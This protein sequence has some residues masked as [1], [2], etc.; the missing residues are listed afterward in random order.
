MKRSILLSIVALLT[1]ADAWTQPK[2]WVNA[3]DGAPAWHNALAFALNGKIY[4]CLGTDQ[5]GN[6]LTQLRQ[7]DPANGVWS[8]KAAFP[9]GAR[10]GAVCFTVNN[11]AYVAT[12]VAGADTLNDLWEY[13]PTLDAWNARADLPGSART[14]AFAFSIDPLG[15]VATGI[16]EPLPDDGS[17]Y[18]SYPMLGDLWVYDPVTDM[19]SPRADLFSSY[20]VYAEPDPEW[21]GFALGGMGYMVRGQQVRAYDPV[22]N[23]WA[24]MA[25]L[26]VFTLGLNGPLTG[27]AL[28]GHGYLIN[29]GRP[30]DLIHQT[31]P[32]RMVR[33]DPPADAWRVEAFFPGLT[34]DHVA[35]AVSGPVAYLMGGSHLYPWFYLDDGT[36]TDDYRLDLPQLWTY[37]VRDC[38]GTVDGPMVPGD[39]CDDGNPGTFN[40]AYDLT[41]TCSGSTQPAQPFHPDQIDDTFT[42]GTGF[43]GEVLALCLQPDGKVIAAGNFTQYNGTACNGIARLHPDGSIDAD[44]N[45]AVGGRA[46]ALQPNGRILVGGSGITRLMPDGSPD[47]SFDTYLS[48]IGLQPIHALAVRPDGSILAGGFYVTTDEWGNENSI[49]LMQ[50]MPDGSRDPAFVPD[51]VWSTA[52]V[53]ALVLRPDGRLLVGMDNNDGT[54]GN[55]AFNLAELLPNGDRSEPF[56]NTVGF[57]FYDPVRAIAV[58]PDDFLAIGGDF[59]IWDDDHHVNDGVPRAHMALLEPQGALHYAFDPGPSTDGPVRTLVAGPEGRIIAGGD[60]S[61]YRNEAHSGIVQ[62]NAY[63]YADPEFDPGT[64]F[65]AAVNVLLALPNGD[66][67]VGGAFTSYDGVACGHITRLRT[68]GPLCLPTQLTTTADPVISCGAV[69]L[70]F[71][72]TSTIAATEVPGANRYQFR[73]TNTPGQPAYTRHIAF[74]SRSF[75]LQKWYTLPL[76]AGRTYNVVVRASFDNGA[77]WCDWGPSCTVKISWTPLAPFAEPRGM[78][79]AY[80]EEPTEL[81]L[82]PNPTNGDQVRIELGGID[83]ELAVAS[84]DI[85]ALFGKRVWST[86]LPLQDGVLNTSLT[87]PGDL[88][89]GLYVATIVA[90]EQLFTERL[91]IAR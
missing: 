4:N 74:P 83:P 45:G 37:D 21:T 38:Q 27:F 86:P 51:L 63:G 65:D 30:M 66:L 58:R 6:V 68:S 11:K 32:N 26:D 79:T 88:A 60:F 14:H 80:T 72:G 77:T 33:Y 9:G 25:D 44:F 2:T 48:G 84:L 43:D 54:G 12:G 29:M 90:G 28:G 16:G 69:N 73:F 19:W 85:T 81:L 71:N 7:Y 46:L 61:Y 22:L 49:G 39:P 55:F 78:E 76:K 52:K 18:M 35:L 50:L 89:G 31:H 62:V 56:M 13:D 70:K 91:M 23:T 5:S 20:I 42:A 34:R 82:F 3:P 24:V 67:L 15:Y 64:G 57:S 40:D 10:T 75:I 47:P 8:M 1:V 36:S 87:L 17:G 53:L 59:N 41:C